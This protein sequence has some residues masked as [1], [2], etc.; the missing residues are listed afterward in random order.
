MRMISLADMVP[1][2]CGR[3]E[4]ILAEGFLRERLFDMGLVAGTMA[5]CERI[6]PSG[7][8][9]VYIVRSTRVAIRHSDGKQVLVEV[10]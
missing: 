2:E 7:G 10:C 6:A 9:S 4:R 1:G 8:S 3:L 5:R